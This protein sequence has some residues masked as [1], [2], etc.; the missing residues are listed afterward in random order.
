MATSA[1]LV[2]T[3]N[4]GTRFFLDSSRRQS[5]SVATSAA[6]GPD[7]GSATRAACARRGAAPRLPVFR[8]RFPRG[9]LAAAS[10]SR[11]ALGRGACAL[12]QAP[13][14]AHVAQAARLTRVFLVAEVLDEREHAT[15]AR[16]RRSVAINASCSTRSA[17]W[18][19]Y[20]A[21]QSSRPRDQLVFDDALHATVNPQLFERFVEVGLG[22]AALLAQRLRADGLGLERREQLFEH[23]RRPGS[24]AP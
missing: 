14:R 20:G 8:P 10:D 15:A 9:L 23:A 1:R 21:R 4:A 24:R 5:R 2:S 3:R 18:A 12:M 11:S 17:R 13:R 22:D 7:D 19:A 16:L 6:L